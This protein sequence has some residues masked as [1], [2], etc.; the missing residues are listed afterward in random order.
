MARL[1]AFFTVVVV[2]VACLCAAAS[3]PYAMAGSGAMNLHPSSR[4]LKSCDGTLGDC[5]ADNDESETSSPLN[6]VVRRSLARKPTARY[7]SYGALKADQVPCNKRGQ[8]YYT[9]CASMKQAN[10]YQRG[11]SAITRCARNMN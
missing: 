8:S 10:P 2:L 5:V 9:N 1:V 11:C 3:L 7:I 4:G 6:A